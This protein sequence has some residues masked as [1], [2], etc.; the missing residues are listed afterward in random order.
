MWYR[1]CAHL[2]II[3][4]VI[5]V[6]IE[7]IWQ[8]DRHVETERLADGQVGKLPGRQTIQRKKSTDVHRTRQWLTRPHRQKMYF[9]E[10][11]NATW[12]RAVEEE[13]R[14]GIEREQQCF[15]K[16]WH[17]FL[18]WLCHLLC[19]PWSASS[20]HQP[21]CQGSS[22]NLLLFLSSSPP[23]RAY[24]FQPPFK[25]HMKNRILFCSIQ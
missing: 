3:T 20:Q 4:T 14:F 18:P 16:S 25:G 9:S 23:P 2:V 12:A 13:K 11:V 6:I 22:H 15:S 19:L 8:A 17:I 5:K 10:V 24:L 1:A 21:P 7:I